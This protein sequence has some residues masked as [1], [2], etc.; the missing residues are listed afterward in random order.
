MHE[1]L[2][3]KVREFCENIIKEDFKDIVNANLGMVEFTYYNRV[4]DSN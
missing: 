2:L 4:L 1:N 3:K